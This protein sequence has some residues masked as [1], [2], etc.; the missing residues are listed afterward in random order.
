LLRALLNS[1]SKYGS[2]EAGESV[3]FLQLWSEIVHLKFNE[4]LR[5]GL[6]SEPRNIGKRHP[7]GMHMHAAEFGAAVRCC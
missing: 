7:P 3:T 5:L 6:A 2:S 1:P 4:K